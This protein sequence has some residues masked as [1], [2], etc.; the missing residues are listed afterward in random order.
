[1]MLR[2][3]KTA[4]NLVY[5]TDQLITHV[6]LQ[7]HIFILTGT[8]LFYLQF[9]DED[10]GYLVRIGLGIGERLKEES[11]IMLTLANTDGL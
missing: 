9:I 2:T 10:P 8:L 3:K 5:S 4:R 11:E 6:L 7:V 1:M